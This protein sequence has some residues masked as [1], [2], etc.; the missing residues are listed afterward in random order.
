MSHERN[1]HAK[2]PPHPPSPFAQDFKFG[3]SS[4]NDDE[5][6]TIPFPSSNAAPLDNPYDDVNLAGSRAMRS[7][8]VA[9]STMNPPANNSSRRMLPALSRIDTSSSS[10]EGSADQNKTRLRR[11]ASTVAANSWGI[12]SVPSILSDF[13]KHT[14]HA[15]RERTSIASPLVTRPPPNPLSGAPQSALSKTLDDFHK[16][17]SEI[18]VLSPA[19]DSLEDVQIE[20]HAQDSHSHDH[21]HSHDSHDHSHDH[22]HHSHHSHSHA[23]VHSHSSSLHP[24]TH[25][26]ELLPDSE[27]LDQQQQQQPLQPPSVIERVPV[28]I[29]LPTSLLALDYLCLK[30]SDNGPIP[31]FLPTSLVSGP[32]LVLTGLLTLVMS[33]GGP[34]QQHQFNKVDVNNT[35]MLAVG[36][37]LLFWACSLIG[38]VKA[39]LVTA[40]LFNAPYL[41]LHPL[42]VPYYLY[43][44]ILYATDVFQTPAGGLSAWKQLACYLAL[45]GS[46]YCLHRP[47][48]TY[49]GI[50]SLIVGLIIMAPAFVSATSYSLDVISLISITSGSFGVFLLTKRDLHPNRLNPALNT[51]LSI[52][53]ERSVL[54]KGTIPY[55]EVFY[56]VVSAAFSCILIPDKI[57]PRSAPLFDPSSPPEQNWGIIDSI[58]AHDDTKNIFYFLLL[59]FSFMLIQL[60]YSILSHSLGLLSDSIHM[61]FDCLALFVGLIASILSKLP[62]SSRF[63]YGLGKVETLSGFTN[64]FFL[65]GI[66]LGVITEAVERISMPVELEKTTELLIVSVLGLV[67]NIVGIFAFNH[68]HSHGGSGHSHSHA[69]F[70]GSDQHDHGHDHGHDHSHDHGHDHSHDHGHDHSHEQEHH[71]HVDQDSENENMRGIFLHIVA[72]TLGSVGVIAST[73]LIYYFGWEGFDPIAS[74]FIAVLIFMSA[75]PLIS[76]AAKTLLLS[77][78]DGQEYNVR[79]MLSDISVMPGVAGYTVPRFWADGSRIRGV[80]HVQVATAYDSRQVKTRVEERLSRGGVRAFVQVEP[81]G[82]NCW[83]RHV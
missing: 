49:S 11:A 22:S 54:L 3:G 62:P 27:Y 30:L 29:S 82:S 36:T 52:F 9:P 16:T 53:L 60:L 79:D 77:L 81:E 55:Q 41:F 65:I 34:A 44:A 14:S 43:L 78:N 57:Y 46:A 63:P 73:L 18:N 61:F 10:S 20:S 35:L 4:V 7:Y 37:L 67:V 24:P 13:R 32:L 6:A 70:G 76:S 83:C 15:Q 47:S 50:V 19:A 59:N 1:G 40:T 42:N 26:D 33:R 23:P 25:L 74:I 17:L 68:G 5:N 28:L 45:I 66:S 80:I 71:P 31:S 51:L 8:S 64:G 21:S 56:D 75:V 58:L 39:C 72:D 48:A 12:H 69:L 38:S 2:P